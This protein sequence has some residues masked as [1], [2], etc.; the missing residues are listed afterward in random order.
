MQPINIIRS[1][2]TLSPTNC[3]FLEINNK[4]ISKRKSWTLISQLWQTRNAKESENEIAKLSLEKEKPGYNVECLGFVESDFMEVGVLNNVKAICFPFF[5]V[6]FWNLLSMQQRTKKAS[7]R[8]T[9]YKRNSFAFL[10][11]F[12]FFDKYSSFADNLHYLNKA[13][14]TR[15]W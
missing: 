15:L 4:K 14:S 10:F 11:F 2:F 7:M 12:S 3:W 6:V 5:M 8:D 9:S 13:L 1:Q